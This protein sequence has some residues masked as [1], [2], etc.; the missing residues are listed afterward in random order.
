M[1]GLSQGEAEV[2]AAVRGV[3]NFVE[4]SN[5]V[6]ELSPTRKVVTAR[7]GFF[8]AEGSWQFETFGCED[9]VGPRV[10]QIEDTGVHKINCEDNPADA[11]ESPVV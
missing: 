11:P 7:K 8:L 1:V 10:H 2:H 9:S 4:L 5:V 6:T 3:E